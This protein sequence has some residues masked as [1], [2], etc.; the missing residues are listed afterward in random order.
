MPTLQ[1]NWITQF[2]TSDLDRVF[3]LKID[4]QDNIIIVGNTKG[5]LPDASAQ[6]KGFGDAFVAKYDKQGTLL[7]MEQFGTR[8]VDF[9]MDVTIDA[10]NNIYITGYT[11]ARMPWATAS[12]GRDGFVKKLNPDGEEIWI[13]QIGSFEL[14]NIGDL[15]LDPDG[16]VILVGMTYGT[17]TGSADKKQARGE[18]WIAKLTAS[19]EQVWLRQL[20][21]QKRDITNAIAVTTD[22]FGNIYAAGR[23]FD[24]IGEDEHLGSGDA[25]FSKLDTNGHFLWVKQFGTSTWDDTREILSDRFGNLFL[26]GGTMGEM[27]GAGGTKHISIDPWVA[28]YNLDGQQKWIRQIS[29]PWADEINAMSF[30]RFGNLLVIGRTRTGIPG[31]LTPTKGN[32]AWMGKFD[33][34]GNLLW[35]DHISTDE[36]DTGMGIASN[37]EGKIIVA[38]FTTGAIAD[39]AH[40][41]RYD[42]WLAEYEEVLNAEEQQIQEKLIPLYEHLDY[43]A[44]RILTLERTIRELKQQINPAEPDI[45][46]PIPPGPDPVGE[47]IDKQLAYMIRELAFSNVGDFWVSFEDAKI[48]WNKITENGQVSQVELD[49]LEKMRERYNF[50]N[51]AWNWLRQQIDKA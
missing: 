46:Q 6:Q 47:P 32:D 20:G 23:T 25:W 2:G 16:N 33:M 12:G 22:E 14:D 8:K 51:K 42:I 48:L 17:I 18:A 11:I 4:H 10:A 45:P 50:T 34:Q 31:A 37:S 9:A 19:G 27:P 43:M 36:W 15:C 7:W 13:K 26:A 1:Q 49:T 29:A 40:Q 30:D 3:D 24:Q 38:G 35:A 41:G 5:K 28:R 21:G 44:G 39:T